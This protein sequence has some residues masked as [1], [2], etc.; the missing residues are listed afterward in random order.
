[1]TES[2]IFSIFSAPEWTDSRLF[3]IFNF[4]EKLMRTSFV[5]WLLVLVCVSASAVPASA[6]QSVAQ[7]SVP[8]LVQFSGVLKDA[9]ARPVAGV[10]SVT[11]AIYAEQEGGAALWS[12]TQNVLADSNGH[13][14]IVLGAATTGGF[15]VELFGTGQSR[16]L[17]VSVARQPEMPR[18]LM[19]SVPYALKAGDAETLGGLPASSYV[20]MQQL[21]ASNARPATTY[22][23]GGTAI[24]ATPVVSTAT[25]GDTTNAAQSSAIQANPTGTGTT[26]FI[27][28][29]TSG[30]NLGNSL[31]FQTGGKLGVG[32]TTPASTLDIN[33]GEIL[34]GGFYE[35]PQGTAT[36]STG[37]PSHSF[38]WL[39]SVF[40]S[41]T[42]KPVDIAYGFRAVPY[43]NNTAM[44][45]ASLDLFY[46]TGGPDGS[47]TDTGLLIGPNGVIDFVPSQTF[48]GNFT[49]GTTGSISSSEGQLI[50]PSQNYN[51]AF[52]INAL[53]NEAGTTGNVAIGTVAMVSSTNATDDVAIGLSALQTA[54]VTNDNV[55]VGTEALFLDQTG[56]ANVAVGSETLNDTTTGNYNV[57]VGYFADVPNTTG[58]KNTFLG[59]N[60]EPA[61]GTMT[62]ATAIGANAYVSTDNS[63][64]L[65]SINGVNGATASVNVGIGVTAPVYPLEVI[66][67]GIAAGTSAI[68]GSTAYSGHNGIYG[69]ANITSGGSNGGYFL[70]RSPAGAGI[71]ATNSGG[72]LAAS[73][74]GDVQITGT[75]TKGGG[76]FKIDDPIDPANKYLSHSFVESPDMMNI[77]N[78]S[79]ILNAKGEAVVTMPEWF[80]A[81]NRDFQYQLTAIGGPAPHLYVAT[82]IQDNQFKI[83][84]GKKGQKISWM[85]TGIRQDAWANAHRIPTEEEKPANEQGRYLHP[86]LFGAG[87][88]KSVN[89]TTTGAA[90]LDA[91]K[92]SAVPSVANTGQR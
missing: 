70:S 44:P 57:A 30:S 8:R 64:V 15:P 12:E 86:E 46:G 58:N 92:A 10:S 17:G 20:T 68:V 26:D 71:V 47:T 4:E 80:S 77:Y 87:P 91:V 29:W 82:E 31:L 5:L 39:A 67:S 59:A 56:S 11:F 74:Q 24:I 43:G 51:A 32:T 3:C 90:S 53:P 25:A 54:T 34:R 13:Y 63:L 69:V 83:A 85:V 6:Q 36:S 14:S 89:A 88:D 65:G 60:S 38:Q 18:I 73:L 19:A 84:G 21:Q 62:N 66:D 22:V 52:G 72:G 41:S 61:S 55:A 79:V 42:G 35:Y 9:G 78:G 33:G 48:S 23:G 76:S 50:L 27:P 37:Q 49:I 81:L 45:L 2:Q 75:L 16:W 1:L 40:N 7:T 28:L